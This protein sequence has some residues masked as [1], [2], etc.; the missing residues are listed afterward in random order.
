LEDQVVSRSDEELLERARAA[1]RRALVAGITTIRDLGDRNFVTL[2]LAADRALPTVLAAGPP[3]TR[4]DGHCWFLGGACTGRE[5][6]VAAVHE[7]KRRGCD[8]VKIMATGGVLTPAFPMWE[9]QF[10]QAELEAV[11]IAAHAVGLPVA[12]HCHGVGGIEQALDAGV[13]TIEH[14]TFFTS[15]QRSEPNDDLI[16][17]I[18]SSQITVSATLGRLPGIPAPAVVE[19][20]YG[21]M[22]D[23]LRRL[24]FE[25]AKVVVGTDA[26]VGPAKPHDVLAHAARDLAAVG[27]AGAEIL[28]T[29]TADAATACGV[30]DRKG[31]LVAGFDADVIAVAGDPTADAEALHQIRGVW[32]QGARVV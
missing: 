8:V 22:I 12:A 14:C 28:R 18:A 3:L 32:R 13:D 19:E 9:S 27:F 17:R 30:G 2:A 23:G 24:R 20:N 11:V 1:A 10:T 6:L 26:G 5:E 7:R 15:N 31:R 29:L 16:Q 4:K 21:V 25:G